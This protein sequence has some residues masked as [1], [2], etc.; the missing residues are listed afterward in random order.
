VASKV[1]QSTPH[2]PFKSF[3]PPRVDIINQFHVFTCLHFTVS[4]FAWILIHWLREI[5]H[6]SGPQS[7]YLVTNMLIWFEE[8]IFHHIA[9]NSRRGY[10]ITCCRHFNRLS[11]LAIP[12]LTRVSSPD[13]RPTLTLAPLS[14]TTAHQNIHIRTIPTKDVIEKN[15]IRARE[16]DH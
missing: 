10:F 5:E 4:G 15:A 8:D 7:A 16:Q 13:Q 11:R 12:P 1:L 3:T 6:I 2:N 14:T 9:R